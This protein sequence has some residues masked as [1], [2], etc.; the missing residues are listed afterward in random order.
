LAFLKPDIENRAFFNVLGLFSKTKKA[1][2]N[3]ALPNFLRCSALFQ[4]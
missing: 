2:R 3:L 1:G 4:I